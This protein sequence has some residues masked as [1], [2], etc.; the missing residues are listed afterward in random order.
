[1]DCCG[2]AHAGV[3]HPWMGSTPLASV[4]AM[5]A[6]AAGPRFDEGWCGRR[7]RSSDGRSRSSSP[8]PAMHALIPTSSGANR[9]LD[10]RV[11]LDR[12]GSG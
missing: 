7:I 6:G 11:G 4:G 12:P 3:R 8:T 5:L 2:H 10:P 1:M 9:R